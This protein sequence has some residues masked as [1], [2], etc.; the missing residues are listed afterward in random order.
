MEKGILHSNSTLV[1]LV[2]RI[3]DIVII[4][5][6]LW[7]SVKLIGQHW[8]LQHSTVAV[9]AVFLFHFTSELDRLYISWRGL[10]LLKEVGKTFWHWFVSASV[11]FLSIDFLELKYLDSENLQFAW[12]VL[13]TFCL[14]S[15]RLLLR[16]FLRSLRAQGVNTRT[17]VIAGAGHLGRKLSK[18]IIAKSGFGLVFAGY[19]DDATPKDELVAAQ[20]IGNLEQLVADCKEGGIDR[21]YVVLPAKADNRIKWLVRE[22]SDSTVSVYIVPDVFTYQLLHSR[23][24]VIEG[25]ATISIYDSPIEG[26]NVLI[27]RIEDIV[28]SSLILILISPVLVGLALAVKL[29]SNGPVFFKQN[30]YGIDGKPI[31]V[32]KFR[33]MNVMEDG[34]KVTQATK[35]DDRFTPIGR[36][37]R[38]TSLD[39]LPQ[40]INVLQGQMSIVGPRPHAVAH[41]EE[42]RRLVDGYMLRHKVK[43]G[44]TGWAQINGWRGET[45]TLDKMEKRVEFDLD[46]IR[47]WSLFLDLK[48]VF[49]TIFKGFV[50]KNAY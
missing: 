32:W 35:N 44:I 28:L 13:T 4:V 34:G 33:S 45:D 29:T 11:I 46:Y 9:V 20:T 50:N 14:I 26:S 12:F 22:L 38:R 27:K 19:Y 25:I 16:V 15:Y 3:L 10:S 48:I 18:S 40:F 39:E 23:S 21:V 6:G 17:V 30:R 31:K 36:F 43:P 1:S 42:Y 47:H 8:E 49:L 24:D 5:G 37:I 7:F 41:N 2:H